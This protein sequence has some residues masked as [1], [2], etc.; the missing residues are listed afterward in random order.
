MKITKSDLEKIIKEEAVR[1]FQIQKLEEVQNKINNE[2]N[3]ISEGKKK[4][5]D[6]ELTELLAGLK[7]VFGAGAQKVGQAVAGAAQKAGQAVAGA[8]EKAKEV[9]GKIASKY[10]EGETTA[11]LA[12]KEKRRD[13]II[14]G[15]K[16]LADEYKTLTGKRYSMIGQKID[17]VK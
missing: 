5:T 8:G 9:G 16:K 2:L 1:M 13:E 7:S 11:A 4:M 14:V 12:K 6:E 15:I 3:L 10:K 17:A